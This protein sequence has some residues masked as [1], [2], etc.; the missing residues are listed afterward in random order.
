MMAL[1]GFRYTLFLLFI[2]LLLLKHAGKQMRFF[3]E[4]IKPRVGFLK[5][6]F[7]P[8]LKIRFPWLLQV[9]CC[10]PHLVWEHVTEMM[11][12]DSHIKEICKPWISANI[13]PLISI[14]DKWLASKEKCILPGQI[15][16]YCQLYLLRKVKNL[17][18]MSGF[19]LNLS[20]YK[21]KYMYVSCN[22]TAYL[23]VL[24][25]DAEQESCL[26]SSRTIYNLLNV[27]FWCF[28]FEYLRN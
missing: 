4:K 27:F 7:D 8:Q 9:V 13:L 20:V 16:Y 3:Y 26:C 12:K 14:P 18:F 19:S 15:T 6:R 21:Y 11:K 25:K 1:F 23:M 28:E 5:A 24:K 22:K 17:K 2:G 10:P